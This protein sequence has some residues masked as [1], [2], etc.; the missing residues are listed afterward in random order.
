[1]DLKEL[2]K[3]GYS[4][5]QINQINLAN[6]D[7]KEILLNLPPK[8][9]VR[10]FRDIRLNK[11]SGMGMISSILLPTFANENIIVTDPKSEIND[12]LKDNIKKVFYEK[13]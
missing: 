9:P 6:K 10:L 11:K 4:L 1:M 7:T 5:E 12:Y 3:K 13:N 8:V 2:L